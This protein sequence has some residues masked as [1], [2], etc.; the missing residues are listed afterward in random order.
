MLQVVSLKVIAN[1]FH[2]HSFLL[3]LLT[4]SSS[5]Q[6][7]SN[8]SPQQQSTPPPQNPQPAFN[9]FANLGVPFGAP[10]FTNTTAPGATGTPLPFG[11]LFN[12]PAFLQQL[13]Q[14]ISDP[15]VLDAVIA[16]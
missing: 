11:D 6:Q 12:N 14:M 3:F 10:P 1:E 16:S 13:T 15:A 2:N 8:N 4:G 9:P 7:A 5:S